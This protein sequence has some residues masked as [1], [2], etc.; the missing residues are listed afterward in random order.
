MSRRPL[1][2]KPLIR[3]TAMICGALL[4]LVLAVVIFDP[5]LLQ[6][7]RPLWRWALGFMGT[8]VALGLAESGV[9][10]PW[11]EVAEITRSREP[12]W[13]KAIA[14]GLG[15]ILSLGAF[16]IAFGLLSLGPPS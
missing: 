2:A 11:S 3:R 1:T 13:I 14:I 16:A 6:P 12:T 10:Y 8:A 9:G 5:S 4:L 15:I 7:S